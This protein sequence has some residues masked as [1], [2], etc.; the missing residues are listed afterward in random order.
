MSRAAT[1]S[2]SSG[3]ARD[4]YQAIEADAPLSPPIALGIPAFLRPN[5][6]SEVKELAKIIALA[7]W[8]PECY[9]DIDGNYI[10][11]KIELAIMQ[12]ATV[13]LGPIASVQSIA[14]IDGKPCIWGDGALAVIA[15]SGLL[16]DMTEEYEPE[17]EQGLV[18]VCTMK[19]RGRATP[20]INRFST[21]MAD[22]AGL[23]QIDGPWQTYPARMLRMRARS[24]TMRD[25]FADVL[26]G[27]HIREE[28][29]DFVATRGTTLRRGVER[30]PSAR[31]YGSPRP[32]RSTGVD[33]ARPAEHCASATAASEG[34][35]LPAGAVVPAPRFSRWSMPTV[36]SSMSKGQRVCEPSSNGSCQLS[37]SRP[38]KSS[39]CGSRTSPLAK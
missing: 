38:S 36:S 7:E 24:W 13:G 10:Q 2:R 6:I 1:P 8:A 35:P 25:G 17:D 12:G 39:A 22:D 26:R 5:S 18:A 23:T 3:S 29:A 28:V 16:E 37:I 9:R 27:L 14:I 21:A 34:E 19:R 15:H 4:G 30:V 31:G 33:L 20:I 32:L 11:P